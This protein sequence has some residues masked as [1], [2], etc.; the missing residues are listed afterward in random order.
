MSEAIAGLPEAPPPPPPK[1]ASAVIL[2]RRAGAGVEVFWLKREKSLRFA[3]GFYAFPGGRVDRA[4]STVPVV[5]ASGEPATLV[6]AAARE[7]F[8]EA[9]VLMVRGTLPPADELGRARQAVLDETLAFGQLLSTHA[10]TL[11]VADYVEA[12]RWVTPPFLAYRFDARFYLVEMPQGQA[13]SV[14]KGEL[15]LGEWVSPKVALERWAKAETLLHPP[16]LHALEVLSRFTSVEAASTALKAPAQMNAEFMVRRTEF[17]RGIFIFPLKTPTL[18]PAAYTNAYLLGTRELVIV[19]P[20]S[21][22]DAETSRLV[23]F[24][25]ELG[26]EGY[27]PKAI[28]LTHHHGDHVGGAQFLRRAL[29]VPVWAHELTAQQLGFPV[30]RLLSEGEVL[31]LD[32][33]LPMRWQVL[34]TPGHA[35]GHLTLVDERTR[36]AVVGDMVAGVGTIIIDPPEGDMGEYLRQLARLSSRVAAIYPAHGPVIPDGPAKLG[37]YLRH[38]A[39]REEK[40]R[41]A[42]ERLGTP[43]T[44]D[45]VVPVAYDDVGE[46]VWPIAERN[47]V[48]ILEKLRAEGRAQKEGSRWSLA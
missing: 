30:D 40:V 22:D 14:W 47:T 34:H 46:F 7:L 9:G 33:P 43:S 10:L 42:L 17:Q 25:N 4:D 48:A 19:D 13:T 26:P 29:K 23:D 8:E 16:N 41:A 20:G 11:H 2:F 38:R 39:W 12:G 27:V 36:S 1:N 6:V 32:G 35:R 28:V 18:P 5:G 31:T 3:A 15:E 44:S 24:I 45:E 37:E 21:P